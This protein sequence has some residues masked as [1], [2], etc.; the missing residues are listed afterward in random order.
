[1]RAFSHYQDLVIVEK[2]EVYAN[3]ELL[4][5]SPQE[6]CPSK[7]RRGLQGDKNKIENGEQELEPKKHPSCGSCS[8]F[9]VLFSSP[10]QSLRSLLGR[11][12]G[13]SSWSTFAFLCS[14]WLIHCCLSCHIRRNHLTPVHK[15]IWLAH[16]HDALRTHTKR[17]L[18]QD[19]NSHHY[20]EARP[21]LPQ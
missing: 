21:G 12:F 11:F 18:I 9:S 14:F 5:L 13:S 15:V 2:I 3:C 17:T 1:M 10:C 19:H 7:E 20:C 6:E 16:A 8:A 4:Q